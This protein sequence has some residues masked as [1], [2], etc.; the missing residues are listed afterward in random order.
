MS[1]YYANGAV[2]GSATSGSESYEPLMRGDRVDV[3]IIGGGITGITAAFN[4]VK[5]GLKVAVIEAGKVG[6]GSTGSSTGN[7][8]VP[9]GKF[10]TILSKHGQKTLD[11]VIRSRSS[12][13]EFIADRVAEFSINCSFHR[14]PWYYFATKEKDAREIDK[15]RDAIKSSGMETIDNVPSGFPFP[16]KSVIKVENQ[17]QFNP[18]QYVKKLAAS[19][20]GENCRIYENSRVT[21]VTDGDPCLVETHMGVITAGKVIHATHTPKGIYAVHAM[22]EVYREYAVAARLNVQL[23]P[24]IYWLNDENEKYSIR[25]YTNETGSYLIVLDDKH[26]TGHKEDTTTSFAKI[27]DYIKSVF[28]TEDIIYR[29]AAQNY[30]PADN[31]PY[32]GTSPLQ[33]NTY[34]ATGFEADG[35][36]YGTAAAMIISDIITGRLNSSSA[37]Y[38]P[39]RFT[40]AASAKKTLKENLDVITHLVNDYVIKEPAK[41]SS[42]MRGE[43]RIVEIKG[44]MAAASRDDSGNLQIVSAVCPHLG[45][46]VHWNIAEKSWDCPCHGSRFAA[47]GSF[48]EGPAFSDL[49]KFPQE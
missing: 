23:E 36:V 5:R 8:Y 44:K 18:L 2:W 3:A 33:K 42:I 38:D 9:T 48:L 20:A 26:K 30:S 34:I 1:K 17:A 29:W 25:T 31:L 39:K 40:P 41:L 27:G 46:Q 28:N 6:M 11:E 45:C 22:M 10:H 14:V 47:D 32:I 43:G 24:G 12:A 35:L 49:E 16:V 13:L 21:A 4:L 37:V 15:E 7:L 19:I